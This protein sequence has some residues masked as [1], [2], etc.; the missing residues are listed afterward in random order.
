VTERFPQSFLDEIRARLPVSEVVSKRVQLTKAGRE[1]KGLS[2]FNKERT[3]SFFVND[4]KGFFHDFS[5]GKHGDQFTFVME[6]DGLDFVGA[7]E[8]LAA[9]AGLAV[10]TPR[11][12]RHDPDGERRE[13]AERERHAEE[14]ERRERKQRRQEAAQRAKASWLWSRRRQIV[15][16]SPP[17]VYLRE[18][19]G[20]AGAIPATLGYLP[21]NGDH[22]PAM[23]AA[24]GLAQE[25]EP[26]IIA[27]PVD[28]RAVHIT[29][30]TPHGDKTDVEPV[31][32]TLGAAMGM[33]IVL[34]PPNDLLGMSIGEGIEDMLSAHIATGLGAWAAGAAGFMPALVDV[35]PSYI[36][37]VTIFAHDDPAGQRGALALAERL[38]ERGTLDVFIEGLS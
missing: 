27:P 9:R 26:G 12:S 14:R 10:P 11:D 7:V 23:I 38:D 1:L 8:D 28:V 33:P 5:S 30:L 3:P 37:A 36:E 18:R 24:F 19:R 35:V 15:E 6:A 34:A 25:I 13:Q 20:Y 32:I 31:K 16:G 29:R 2:P 17:W 22:P 4:A 21:P